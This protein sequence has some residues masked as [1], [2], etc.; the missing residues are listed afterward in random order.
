MKIGVFSG[1]FTPPNLGHVMT[2]RKLMDEYDKVVIPI[3]DYP[4][5][6]ECSAKEAKKI[7]EYFFF[8]LFN[9]GTK[10]NLHFVVDNVHFGQI[11][12]YQ[13]A[14]LLSGIGCEIDKITYLSGNEEVLKHIQSLGVPCRFVPRVSISGIDQYLFEST[15][16]R[17]EMEN[18]GKNLEEIYNLRIGD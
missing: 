8:E 6:G 10:S 5:R 14:T 17:K 16:I 13:L 15:R 4:E 18:T 11:S 2:I 7:F 3:L 9:H 12:I 1:R